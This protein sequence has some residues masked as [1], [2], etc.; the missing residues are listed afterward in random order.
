MAST[1]KL[2]RQAHS[3]LNTNSALVMHL[4]APTATHH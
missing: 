3:L 2:N 1:C 4:H